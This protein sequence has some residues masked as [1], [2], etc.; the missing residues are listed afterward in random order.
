MYIYTYIIIW[1]PWYHMVG[2]AGAM[3]YPL[4]EKI[5]PAASGAL[6]RVFEHAELSAGPGDPSTSSLHNLWRKP[7]HDAWGG[8]CPSWKMWQNWPCAVPFP[9]CFKLFQ[10]IS[11]SHA[12]CGNMRID[13]I[14][15]FNLF[16]HFWSG[17]LHSCSPPA[18][19]GNC[20]SLAAEP[21][22]TGGFANS[23][24]PHL[25][26]F[27]RTRIFWN[28]ISL[29]QGM[30]LKLKATDGWCVFLKLAIVEILAWSEG[31]LK[32]LTLFVAASWI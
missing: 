24:V 27:R 32:C 28:M 17:G 12:T 26:F 4:L 15:W 25:S 8:K 22:A 30:V 14:Y 7:F 20:W 10:T 9:Q 29:C 31:I 23:Q 16:I 11:N 6:R 21:T 2:F 13:S 3:I 19:Q 5:Q 1:Y 18:L